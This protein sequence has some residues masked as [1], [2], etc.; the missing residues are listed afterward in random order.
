MKKQAVVDK[1]AETQA[2]VLNLDIRPDSVYNNCKLGSAIK[3]I[4]KRLGK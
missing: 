4:K 2:S 3:K 1:T